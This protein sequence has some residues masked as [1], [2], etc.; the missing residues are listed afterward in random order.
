MARFAE[1]RLVNGPF[2]DP[3]VLVDFRFAARALLFDLGEIEALVPREIVRVSDIFVSHLHMDHFIGFDRLLRVK[4]Y[5]PQTVSLYG[6][7]GL[8]DAVEAKL[9]A[10]SWNLLG[11]HSAPFVLRAFDWREGFFVGS[12][13]AAQRG[14]RRQDEPLPVLGAGTLHQESDFFIEAAVLDHG[15]P[16]LAFAFQERVRI[17]VNKVA[18]AALGLPVGPW[19]SGAKAGMRRGDLDA[20]LAVDGRTVTPQELA[21]AGA[22]V[23]GPGQRIA[24]ATDFGFT[25]ANI[26]GVLALARG[27]ERVFVEAPFLD[28]DAERAL[29]THHLTAGQAGEIAR[30]AGVN[31]ATPM[32]FSTRH[33]R[34]EALL[35]SEFEQA[36]AGRDGSPAASG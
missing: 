35:R 6:P 17:N 20:P 19:L 34:E 3:G 14:F 26:A 15:I 11:P 16:C 22:L 4:L 21:A 36:L 23:Q 25:P 7:P 27:A 13:F 28:R 18:L 31:R 24:Y 1:A 9:G 29:A 10:Y 12:R 8:V 5:Q 32:H 33:L 30:R 2:G